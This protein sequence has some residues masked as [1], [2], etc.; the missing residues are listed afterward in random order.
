MEKNSANF[1]WLCLALLLLQSCYSQICP[2]VSAELVSSTIANVNNS[3][4]TENNESMLTEY[5]L[6]KHRCVNNRALSAFTF[7]F[8][9]I[10]VV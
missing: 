5:D 10:Y 3:I 2:H 8:V 6:E 7:Y 1:V 9:M 4:P